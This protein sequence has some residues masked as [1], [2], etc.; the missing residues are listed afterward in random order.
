MFGLLTQSRGIRLTVLMSNHDLF[1]VIRKVIVFLSFFL[2]FL[3]FSCS[4]NLYTTLQSSP[5]NLPK[6][7]IHIPHLHRHNPKA[8]V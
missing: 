4:R 2:S 1:P 3:C 7:R 8:H 5:S 6:H